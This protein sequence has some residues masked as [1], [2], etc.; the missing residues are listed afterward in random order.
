MIEQVGTQIGRIFERQLA[1]Q[2][3]VESEE[4]FRALV[5]TTSE[6]IWATDTNQKFTYSSPA[7]RDL[8][9][10]T[11]EEVEGQV[12][13]D[14]V[15]EEDRNETMATLS[16]LAAEKSGWSSW[17][18]RW[19]HKDGSF[20]DLE[21][22][23]SPILG[24]EGELLGYRGVARDV[25]EKRILEEQLRRSQKMD[26][27]GQ[28]AGGMAHD[29]NNL[30][31]VILNYSSFIE[32][33]LPDGSALREDVAEISNAGGRA[34]ELVRQLLQFSRKQ[35][36]QP[37]VLDPNEV[38]DQSQKML[39]RLISENIDMQ[40][41]LAEDVARV[42]VDPGQLEQVLVNLVVNA[43]DAMPE[44]GRLVIETQNVELD[45]QYTHL[46][47]DLAPGRYVRIAI[48]DSGAG[49]PA[50][51]RSRIFDPFFTTKGAGAGTGL[52][53]STVYG[54]VQQANGS[55][56]AYSE[57]NL[58]TTFKVYLPASEK[59]P[60]DADETPQAESLAGGGER[61]LV[62]EDEASVR[63]VVVRILEKAGYEVVQAKSGSEAL[64]LLDE[65]ARPFDL[66]I[67]D[68]I[69]PEM[70]GIALSLESGLRTLFI[71]GYTGETILQQGDLV[72][73]DQLLE[74]P[75]TRRQL[76][77]R[78][79]ELLSKSESELPRT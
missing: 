36:V 33:E 22:S 29:F 39:G 28:L 67:T 13:I 14:Y 57:P 32:D 23:A 47:G 78:V 62:A 51:I 12:G 79:R 10:Y 75:F 11:R 56:S 42:E 73:G 37:V 50:D 34:A 17:T 59:D 49:I 72:A 24:T 68:V 70:S 15:Y 60:V 41:K 30:L 53:L 4:K 1:E 38:I 69:M 21:S 6:W 66:L 44:G 71:S 31:S 27:I 20:R 16:R 8:L 25:T 46:K 61:L 76:L 45:E 5:E 7:V 64:R 2:Q 77:E 26:A 3:L 19:R 58:G 18:L 74:K 52:G 63:E 35:I 65:T 54:I 43:K 40:V 55:V 48:T 9:G